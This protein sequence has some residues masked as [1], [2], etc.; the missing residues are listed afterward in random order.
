M[1]APSVD[2]QMSLYTHK[3]Y[4]HLWIAALQFYWGA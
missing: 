3:S 1:L 2:F 4:S